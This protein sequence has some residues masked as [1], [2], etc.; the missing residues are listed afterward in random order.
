[1]GNTAGVLSPRGWADQGLEQL[2]NDVNALS[3]DIN[4]AH[5]DKLKTELE[6][7][8]KKHEFI[9]KIITS[10]TKRKLDHMITNGTDFSMHEMYALVGNQDYGNFMARL[11]S[12]S[13]VLKKLDLTNAL[14]GLGA[15]MNTIAF[16]LCTTSPG[17]M[18]SLVEHCTKNG[19]DLVGTV[20]IKVAKAQSKVFFNGVLADTARTVDDQEIAALQAENLVK[21]DVM[22]TN[23]DE[24]KPFFEILTTASYVQ[25]DRINAALQE[26][27]NKTLDQLIDDKF[28]RKQ[29]SNYLKMWVRKP[30][31]ATAYLFSLVG[32]QPKVMSIVCSR[33]EK[34]FFR[35]VDAEVRKSGLCPSGLAEFIRKNLSGNLQKALVSWISTR[36]DDNGGEAEAEAYVHQQKESGVELSDLLQQPDSCLVIREFYEKAKEELE[37]VIRIEGISKANEVVPQEDLSEYVDENKP[38]PRPKSSKHKHAKVAYAVDMEVD[39]GSNLDQGGDD[40]FYSKLNI[41]ESY[42]ITVFQSADIDAPYGVLDEEVFWATF[43]KMPLTEF[44]MTP[45]EIACARDWSDWVGLN[46]RVVYA[47]CAEEMADTLINVIENPDLGTTGDSVR[48][49]ITEY[50]DKFVAKQAEIAANN[51]STTD[52]VATEGVE[53]IDVKACPDLLEYLHLSFSA[54][55]L[56][57]EQG[58][59]ISFVDFYMVLEMLNLGL[60]QGDMTQIVKRADHDADNV[61]AWKEALPELCNIIHD[62]CSDSRD[63]WLGLM[64]PQSNAGYWYN[65]RDRSSQWMGE[66]DNAY[67]HEQGHAP[68]DLVNNEL[69][70]QFIKSKAILTGKK[71]DIDLK[72]KRDS[73]KKHLLERLNKSQ[74]RMG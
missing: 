69:I 37:G 60:S 38:K 58:D 27:A 5:R 48:D 6:H 18:K 13:L 43:N 28:P 68:D 9:I 36:Y 40:S 61:I 65:V 39:M 47:D 62:M 46:G 26:A 50:T 4:I 71:L 1:M 10:K 74:Q 14:S 72:A 16:I 19:M 73:A 54:H 29:M 44:G 20:D 34:S 55:K 3:N 15:D 63:H 45:D 64:D 21:I 33:E 41:V 22:S 66:E 52:A 51:T 49:V 42:I 32:R 2:I 23:I 17:N 56:T 57:L 59:S 24:V 67:F 53:E 35:E 12:P 25:L 11:C 31:A 7:S 30:A 8:F 70:A